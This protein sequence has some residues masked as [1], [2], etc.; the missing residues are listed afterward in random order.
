MVTFKLNWDAD[1]NMTHKVGQVQIVPR[2]LVRVFGPSQAG[3]GDGKTQAEYWFT[4]E[5]GKVFT[6]YGWKQPDGFEQ[7]PFVCKFSIGGRGADDV[8]T[9]EFIQWLAAQVGETLLTKLGSY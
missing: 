8:E 1:I 3:D 2:D 6:L 4:S 5:T 9:V 7:S